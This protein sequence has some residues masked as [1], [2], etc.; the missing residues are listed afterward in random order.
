VVGASR[1]WSARGPDPDA[2]NAELQEIE[3]ELTKLGDDS[4]PAG[5]SGHRRRCTGQAGRQLWIEDR[6]MHLDRMNIQRDTQD[7][8]AQ[9]VALQELINARGR[10]LAVLLVSLAPGELPQR[11]DMIT[12]AERYLV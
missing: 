8:S 6:V 1:R 11:E 4:V 2:L 9:R 10:R 7:A 5:A 3:T 12:A